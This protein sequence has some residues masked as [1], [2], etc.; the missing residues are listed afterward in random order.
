MPH[1]F[2]HRRRLLG[3]FNEEHDQTS[4]AVWEKTNAILYNVGGVSFVVGSIFFFP[5]LGDYEDVGAWIFFAGS[6]LYLVVTW[7]RSFATGS[8]KRRKTL[9]MSSRR[10]RP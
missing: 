8:P 1:L 5:V 2:T 6:V 7:P 9:V 3:L 4:Q 10:L